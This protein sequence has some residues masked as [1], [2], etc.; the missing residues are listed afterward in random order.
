MRAPE[1]GEKEAGMRGLCS[2]F[3]GEIQRLPGLLDDDAITV[4]QVSL[5]QPPH[6]AATSPSELRGRIM[7]L[8]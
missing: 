6:V 2:L 5:Y 3:V 7:G 1:I 8:S 4:S